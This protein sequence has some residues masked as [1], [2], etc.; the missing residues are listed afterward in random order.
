MITSYI[1]SIC[2][3]MIFLLCFSIRSDTSLI[4]SHII[5]LVSSERRDSR[6][7]DFIR[8]MT[9]CHIVLKL[10]LQES[11]ILYY[12]LYWLFDYPVKTTSGPICVGSNK[13]KPVSI[14]CITRKTTT[15]WRNII[16]WWLL[17][18]S[19]MWYILGNFIMSHLM[20]YSGWTSICYYQ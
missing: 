20:Y 14:T 17:W 2:N 12:Y 1:L 3:D 15:I 7:W 16:R 8:K 5:S 10:H 13:S 19:S 6:E 18:P 4:S 11:N 9:Y